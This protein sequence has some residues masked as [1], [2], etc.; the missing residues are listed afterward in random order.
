MRVGT[1]P[2]GGGSTRVTLAVTDT[3]IGLD[4]EQRARLFQ[5]F[6]QADSSTTA[7]RRNRALVFYYPAAGA[8]HGRAVA[9]E[10]A[11]GV[12]STFI[13]TLTLQAAGRTLRSRR[14]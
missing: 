10:S 12:G 8:G 6:V 11:M 1:V 4:A 5:P 7:I 13:V 9:V 3:G 14:C 2:L